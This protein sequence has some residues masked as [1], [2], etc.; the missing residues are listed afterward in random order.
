MEYLILAIIFIS[1]LTL[2]LF[3]GIHAY[4]KCLNCFKDLQNLCNITEK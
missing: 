4:T 2:G 1:G 3:I